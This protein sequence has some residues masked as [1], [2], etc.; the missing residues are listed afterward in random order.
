M[1]EVQLKEGDELRIIYQEIIEGCSYSPKEFYIKHL[2]ELEK[3]ELT[4]KQRDF[5]AKYIR[6]G[7]PT[8]AERLKHLFETEEWSDTKDNDIT[9]YRQT[10]A[11][12]EKMVSTVILEQQSVIKRVIEEHRQTLISLLT[13][14]RYLIGTTAEELAERD[15]TAFMAYLSLFKDK[16]CSIPIFKT[17]EDFEQLDELDREDYLKTINEL[18]ERFSD[19]AIRGI[20]VLPFFLNAFSYSKDA[21]HTFLNKPICFLTNYQVH[22]FSLGTRNLSVLSQA[23]GSPPEYFGKVTPDDI[24]KWYDTQY[25]IIIAKRKQPN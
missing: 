22:L 7:I 11:D 19:K 6:E 16:K 15:S 25:S 9:A 1:S 17:W 24:V 12:N 10:I 14:K 20:S 8:E 18:L 23:V 3:I 13:E 2:C 4:R 5:T 21:I